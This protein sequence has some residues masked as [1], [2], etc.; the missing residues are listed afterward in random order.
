[1]HLM[2]NLAH[3]VR[4]MKI[5]DAPEVSGLSISAGLIAGNISEEDVELTDALISC[6]GKLYE[7]KEAGRDMVRG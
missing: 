1:M 4:D 3:V 6:D 2:T 5:P 7:A